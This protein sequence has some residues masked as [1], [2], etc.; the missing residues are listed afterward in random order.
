MAGIPEDQKIDKILETRF[1][2]SFAQQAEQL[3]PTLVETSRLPQRLVHFV[4]DQEDFF[5]FHAV[6]EPELEG[7]SQIRLGRGEHIILDFGLHMVGKVNFTINA[8]GLNIDAPCRL[9]LTFGETPL[10]VNEGMENVRTWISTSWLP[11]EIISIDYFPQTVVM[12]RRH[13][14]RYIKFDIIDTSPK[15]S[16]SFEDVSFGAVSSVQADHQIE[17][18]DFGDLLLNNID[19]VSVSTLRDCMQTVFEDGPRRD[20]RLW[21]GDLRL[22]ALTNYCTFKNYDLVKRC[23]F[24]FAA[25]IREDGSLP[26]CLFEHPTLRPATDY[27]VDY[28]ALFAVV[29]CEY[30]EATGDVQAG[31]DLWLTVLSCLQRAISHVNTNTYVF[32]IHQGEGW[33]F[34]DW[35][36]TLDRSAGLHGLLIF[37]LKATNRLARALSRVPP[38]VDLADRMGQAALTFYEPELGVMVSGPEK[39]VS[40]ASV[41]WLVLADVF[42][43]KI[44]Q[45]CLKN[46]LERAD[47]VKPSTPYLW[48]YL[49]EALVG[50][51]LFDETLT[52]I[53]NY[54]G[55]MVRAGADTFWESFDPQDPR[56]S[57]YGDVRNNSFCH[58]W[59]CTPS[60]LLRVRM[61]EHL[62]ASGSVGT[63]EEYDTIW[64]SLV[65]S[66]HGTRSRT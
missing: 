47:A 44:S 55:G 3:R 40:I 53:R 17:R 26:A 66:S 54:W 32:D 2:Q 15:F 62:G 35:K 45:V 39:Q 38:F 6:D 23:I 9:R 34:V 59:S 63:M 8:H 58:A 52:I 30:V 31:Q 49:C 48:H 65:K 22:Q 11:D 12:P 16:V 36:E 37:C 25:V 43:V 60:Y 21:I 20:R 61:N 42:P 10:D 1:N 57:P 7:L 56:S 50:V 28:D 27:I 13:A 41:A 18:V 14:C 64:L 19:H 33:K 24:M 29:V 5:G 51:G 46:V 4:N